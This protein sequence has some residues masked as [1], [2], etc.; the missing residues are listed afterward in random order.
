MDF[1]I[2]MAQTLRIPESAQY[3]AAENLKIDVTTHSCAP[4]L[5]HSLSTLPFSHDNFS[6]RLLH[7]L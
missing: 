1:P 7:R 5:T 2:C 4:G 3:R 6:A